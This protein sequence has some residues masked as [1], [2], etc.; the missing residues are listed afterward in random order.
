MM[1]VRWNRLW[2]VSG[3]LGIAVALAACGSS[4]A[5]PGGSGSGAPGGSGASL[6]EVYQEVD[7][8][9]GKKRMDRLVE[10]AEE[11]G[12]KVGW[13]YVGDMDPLIEGFEEA[14]GLTVAGYE[15]IS[16]DMSERAGQEHET[17]QQ[18]SD[19][20]LG[21][22]V[23]LRTLDSQGL[24]APL[25]T[26]VLDDVDKSYKGHN[27]ISPYANL[28]VPS[29]NTDLVPPDQQP[30]S[31]EDL[32]G[33]PPGNMGIEIGDWQWYENLVLK[34]FVEQKGMTE[35]EAIDL[36]TEGVAGAQQ[37]EG[38]SLVVE[39]LASGEYAASPHSFSHSVIPL[40]EDEA[41]ITLVENNKEM[42][43]IVLTNTMGLTD[44][45]PNPAG[46]LALLEWLM[47]TEAQKTF[48]DLGYPIPSNAYAGE[49]ILDQ[50][51]DAIV[52]D[53]YLTDTPKEQEAWQAK[54]DAL[55][56]AIGGKTASED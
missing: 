22:G 33:N 29:Y 2:T 43:A 26:P 20:L 36:I 40:V 34:Y 45:G 42:P 37:V 47:S 3:L 5:A 50:Y 24:L 21:A 56:Q 11:A 46:G 31:Y 32:F 4:P 38:H 51:P 13:Y 49:N 44:G 54:Y 10:M 52:A 39:L 8:L 30:T 23:D 48:A 55:L 41:P 28:M 7:G 17:N 25:R 15:T 19:V 53:L 6:E 12:G 35:Q 27:A 14:T 16:E 18:G 1:S 9:T